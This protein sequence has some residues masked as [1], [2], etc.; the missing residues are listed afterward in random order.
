M[1]ATQD[2]PGSCTSHDILEVMRLAS[3]LEHRIQTLR[4]GEQV[5]DAAGEV[6]CKLSECLTAVLYAETGAPPAS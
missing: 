5:T 2:Q 6:V 1:S 4:L 3:A